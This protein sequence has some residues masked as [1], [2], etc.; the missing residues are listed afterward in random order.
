M[1][2]PELKSCSLLPHTAKG[3]Y[4]Q[5]PEEGIT[6]EEY[7]R[8][9]ASIKSI[10][11]SDFRGSDGEDEKFCQGETCVLPGAQSSSTG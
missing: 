4:R 9:K 11:W 10:D 3:A 5:M 7:A 8:R 6:K 1:C 2:V